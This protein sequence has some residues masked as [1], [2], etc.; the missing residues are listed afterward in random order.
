MNFVENLKLDLTKT[1]TRCR[2]DPDQ[3]L[4]PPPICQIKAKLSFPTLP[5]PHKEGHVEDDMRSNNTEIL[6]RAIGRESTSVIRDPI[7]D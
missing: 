7:G 1:S 6:L 3:C 2:I 5:D 4:S